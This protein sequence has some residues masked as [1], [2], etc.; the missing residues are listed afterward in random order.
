[1]YLKDKLGGNHLGVWGCQALMRAG[2]SQLQSLSLSKIGLIKRRPASGRR[3]V[4]IYRAG[5]AASWK[6]L[7]SV[8]C[9]ACRQQRNR[10]VGLSLPHKGTVAPPAYA[11]AGYEQKNAGYS[12]V[13][14]EGCRHIAKAHWNSLLLL[15]LSSSGLRKGTTV[16]R[17]RGAGIC[18][19]GREG[20]RFRYVVSR[21]SRGEPYWK[22]G[23]PNAG[24]A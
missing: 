1:M 5:T 21:S 22:S 6:R 2:W 3:A 15:G 20:G 17:T 9:M 7:T 18:A 13:G 4:G 12:R 16:S 23:L 24:I 14:N 8:G 19:R 10:G 11:L